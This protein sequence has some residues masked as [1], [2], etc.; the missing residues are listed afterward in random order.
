MEGEGN[1]GEEEEKKSE[2]GRGVGGE[3]TRQ[4][5]KDRELRNS[6]KGTIGGVVVREEGGRG[7]RTK[8]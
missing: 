4:D 3:G 2:R 6:V 7:R 5:R 8:N 1:G